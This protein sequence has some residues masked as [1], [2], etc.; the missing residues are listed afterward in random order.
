[1]LDGNEVDIVNPRKIMWIERSEKRSEPNAVKPCE[2]LQTEILQRQSNIIYNFSLQFSRRYD[3]IC[4]SVMYVYMYVS[5]WYRQIFTSLRGTDN[6]SSLSLYGTS[7]SLWCR[8]LFLFMFLSCI[9]RCL[10]T[11]LCQTRVGMTKQMSDDKEVDIV[12]C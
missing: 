1:M 4:T 5:A 7:G 11:D 3:K 10:F 8:C 6:G 9:R 2:F 12:N